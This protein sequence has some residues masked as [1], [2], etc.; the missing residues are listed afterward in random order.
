THTH[1][2]THTHTHTVHTYTH[3]HTHAHKQTHTHTHT[4]THTLTYTY[5]HTCTQ[6]DTCKHTMNVI[7]NYRKSFNQPYKHKDT[8]NRIYTEYKHIRIHRQQH[9]TRRER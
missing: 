4:Y 3:T 7:N 9:T 5:T 6:T 2:H 1:R 8:H